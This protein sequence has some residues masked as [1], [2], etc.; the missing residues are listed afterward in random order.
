VRWTFLVAGAYGLFTLVPGYFLEAELTATTSPAVANPE[1]YYG[2]Y[3]IAL[4]WQ[5]AFFVV[6]TDPIRFRP[7]VALSVLEKLSF[8]GTCLVLFLIG[9]LPPGGPLLGG[10]VDAVWMILFAIAW[11]RTCA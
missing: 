10:A 2:F 5:I 1:F 11:L 6:A 9:R 3:R 4:V 8:F 7:L